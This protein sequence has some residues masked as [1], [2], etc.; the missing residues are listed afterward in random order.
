MEQNELDSALDLLEWSLG[1]P[2]RH[3]MD[4]Y[5]TLAAS[6]GFRVYQHETWAGLKE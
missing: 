5:S 3:L 6:T 1:M 2:A 4:P